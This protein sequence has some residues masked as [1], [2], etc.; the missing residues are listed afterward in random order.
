MCDYTASDNTKLKRHLLKHNKIKNFHCPY[1]NC[2]FA[3]SLKYNLATHIRTHT[4]EMPYSCTWPGCDKT[5]SQKANGDYHYRNTHL[6]KKKQAEELHEN[7]VLGA[8]AN[9]IA[10][11]DVLK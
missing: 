3:A 8:I 7:S 9:D 1:E 11:T 2:T 5:F 6:E 10:N 4:G